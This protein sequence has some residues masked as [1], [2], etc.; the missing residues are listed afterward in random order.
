[1]MMIH[2]DLELLRGYELFK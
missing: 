1:M 2:S